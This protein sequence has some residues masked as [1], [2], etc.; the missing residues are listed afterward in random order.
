MKKISFRILMLVTIVLIL[1]IIVISIFKF[2]KISSFYS[3]NLSDMTSIDIM[4][5]NDGNTANIKDYQKIKIVTDYLSQ[6]RFKRIFT[7]KQLGW[8][9]QYTIYKN[10]DIIFEITFLNESYCKIGN[11]Y[12]ELKGNDSNLYDLYRSLC[13]YQNLE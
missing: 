8:S 11:A 2:K 5:G 1:S 9:Y 7:F 6:L 13:E 4:N 10:D 3:N 12:Y